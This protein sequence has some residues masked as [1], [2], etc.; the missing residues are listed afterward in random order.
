M[1]EQT[2]IA[3]RIA[4]IEAR[5]QE[6]K[7]IDT[8]GNFTSGGILFGGTDGVIASDASNLYW[9]NTNDRLGLGTNAPN[10][11]L[12]IRGTNA[13]YGSGP[14]IDFTTSADVYPQL[15]IL[16]YAHNNIQI[17]FDAKFDGTNWKSSDAGSNF[18]IGKT[19]NILGLYYDSGNTAGNNVASWGE[20]FGIG[21]DGYARFGGVN[22]RIGTQ[23]VTLANNAVARIGT[24][25][26]NVF[27]LVHAGTA[28]AMYVLNGAT[29]TVN[30]LLDPAG[31]YTPTAGTAASLNIYWSGANTRYEIENKRGATLTA[32]FW[33]FDSP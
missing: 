20:A 33:L 15:Q 14:H 12:D 29:N 4:S 30:E 17:A 27:V 11:K 16:P 22:I 31:V 1:S 13:S 7:S 26:N 19:S 21:V 2:D 24:T 18:R 10:T 5:L 25:N 6:L 8:P 32:R 9:D 3:T 28:P 23:L